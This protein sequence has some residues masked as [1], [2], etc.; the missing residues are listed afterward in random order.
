MKQRSF[1]RSS[2]WLLLAIA[3]AWTVSSFT[4]FRGGEGFEVF[5]DDQPVLQHF[6]KDLNKTGQLTINAGSEARELRVLYHHCGQNGTDRQLSL[7][8]ANNKL[9]KTWKFNNAG[10]NVS[11][12]RIPLKEL[13]AFRTAARY[14]LHY[15]SSEIPQGRDLL[16]L[17]TQSGSLARK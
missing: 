1:F 15:Q 8:D 7:R 4:I 6:G 17:K 10:K 13:Q 9:V 12:M 2:F 14:T 3:G 5:I 11:A 16:V